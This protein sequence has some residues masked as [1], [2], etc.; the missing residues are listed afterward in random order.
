MP[1]LQPRLLAILLAAS[2]PAEARSPLPP[3][4]ATSLTGQTV[5]A[6]H[7]IGEPTVLIITPSRRAAGQTEEWANALRDNFEPGQARVRSILSIDLPFFI[8]EHF[9]LDRARARIPPQYHHQTWLLDEPV[10][11]QALGIPPASKEAW[12]VVL[13]S[14]G[15]VMARVRGTPTESGISEIRAA[16]GQLQTSSGGEVK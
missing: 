9:A 8:S 10:L 15:E 1:A 5:T 6:R 7:L 2:T 14:D 3:F 4:T 12:V 16:L 11:E 13:N